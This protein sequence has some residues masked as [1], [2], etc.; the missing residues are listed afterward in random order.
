MQRMG[1]WEEEPPPPDDPRLG[2]ENLPRNYVP[3]QK[4]FEMVISLQPNASASSATLSK[5]ASDWVQ[6]RA[7]L[8]TTLSADAFSVHSVAIG[9]EVDQL[10]WERTHVCQPG[11][12]V[13]SAQWSRFLSRWM[14]LAVESYLGDGK[15]TQQLL[16]LDGVAESKL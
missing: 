5:Q 16:Q 12:D 1:G 7:P 15:A 9:A 14:T 4:P 3:S 11:D 8:L 10:G 13:L 2:E 6:R